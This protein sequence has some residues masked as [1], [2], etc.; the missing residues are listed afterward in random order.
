MIIFIFCG[1]NLSEIIEM[2]FDIIN[3]DQVIF[4]IMRTSNCIEVK[5][6]NNL[7]TSYL[8]RVFGSVGPVLKIVKDEISKYVTIVFINVFRSLLTKI[9]FKKHLDWRGEF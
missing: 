8:S 5:H 4:Y 9:A 7:S 2:L 1:K 6:A 3:I